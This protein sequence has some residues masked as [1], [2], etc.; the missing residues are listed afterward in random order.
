M[1]VAQPIRVLVATQT[2]QVY[3]ILES[4]SD[5]R[6]DIA[7][8]TGTIRDLLP[9][10]QLIIIDYDDIVEYPLSEVE[11]REQI[12]SA[13][14]RECRSEDF[15]A[16]PDSFLSGMVI[17][18][19]GAM[20][21]LPDRYC[22]AFVSY[23]GGI[24]RTT[25][26]LDTAYYYAEAVNKFL[27]NRRVRREGVKLPGSSAMVVELSYGVSSLVSLTGIEM[28]SLMNLA[29]DPESQLQVHRGVSL[30]PMDYD[31][32]R[33]LAVDLLERYFRRQIEQHALTVVDAIWPHG[34]AEALSPFVDLWVVVASERPDTVA[35]ACKLREELAAAYGED[36][37]W[38][39]Q[40]QTSAKSEG[41]Q[42]I[43][44]NIRV[45]R[46]TRADELRGELGRTI[47]SSVFA[48][49]WTDIYDTSG[50]AGASKFK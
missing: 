46:V 30:V 3:E 49:L 9:E 8:Y 33:M 40:N 50:K 5:V 10:A 31:N 23:S 18:R 24:G 48:P 41:N 13:Q 39:L 22:L 16:D 29:T 20:I 27:K 7:L 35:N 14:V 44:W 42:Q 6:Y 45:P 15:I 47:L 34:L 43:P 12:F 19:P 11:L 25:L 21:S 37:V 1:V 26:A 38:L 32:V 17:N 4:R 28:P 36:R 2:E